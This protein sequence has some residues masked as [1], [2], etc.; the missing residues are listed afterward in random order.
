MHILYILKSHNV[1]VAL[2]G[3]NVGHNWVGV[4]CPYCGDTSFH[5]GFP[6]NGSWAYTCFRCGE[7]PFK[8]TLKLLLNVSYDELNDL[9]KDLTSDKE[10][11]VYANS[12]ELIGEPLNK[13]AKQYLI[14]RGFNPE[15]LANKYNLK[16]TGAVGEWA[17]R[18]IIPVYY[19]HQ[20]VSYVGRDYTG[21]QTPKYLALAKTKSLMN[22]KHVLY[23]EQ[24]VQG[25]VIG[26]C[27]GP[28]DAL[29]LGDGFVATFGMKFSEQQ[30]QGL[31]K[32][33][34]VYIIFDPEPLAQKNALAMAEKLSMFGCETEVIDTELDHDPG[35][36]TADEVQQLRTYMGL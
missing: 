21:K 16:S 33:K 29:R 1:P 18:I 3:K 28:F 19:N 8:E 17:L 31:T 35:D 11:V 10:E 20:I 26:V 27:E 7:H 24:F 14:N 36:M 6:K 32:Y 25:D 2:H 30:I 22:I 12:L 9:L 13:Y 15:Y 4:N 23:N 5:G 34:K